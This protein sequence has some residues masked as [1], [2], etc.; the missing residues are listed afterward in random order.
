MFG[1]DPI[2]QI[3]LAVK[4]LAAEDRRCWSATGRSERVLELL[5]L[6]ERLQAETARAVGEWDRGQD[7]ALD[8]ALS[9]RSWLAHRRPIG[10]VGASRLVRSARLVR[11]HPATGDALANGDISCAHVDVLASM[12]RDR[13]PEY[14]RNEDTLLD[15]ARALAPDDFAV[16]AGHWRDIADDDLAK[17]EARDRYERRHVY[18]STTLHGHGVIEGELDAEGTRALLAALDLAAPPDPANGIAPPCTPSQRRADGLVDIAAA[19]L[20]ARGEGGRL[21]VGIDAVIDADTLAG[22]LRSDP[23]AVRCEVDGVGPIPPVTAWRLACDAA[24]RRVVMRGESEVLDLGRS[25]R[26]RQPGPPASVGVARPR[27]RVS[28]VRATRRVVRRAPHRVLGTRRL[29]Q[30]RELPPLVPPSPHDVPRRRL[31]DRAETRRPLRSLR[32][33]G[34]AAAQPSHRPRTTCGRV[35]LPRS[36]ANRSVY[37]ADARSRSRERAVAQLG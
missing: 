13:E 34:V 24:V 37:T 10:R 16:V 28:R 17:L 26:V 5:E 29:D 25:Q 36:G 35:T 4:D 11:D 31:D 22:R 30:P 19:F 33:P 3:R 18:V 23:R 12:V 27:V 21:R 6:T 7:W 2:E 8:G 15:A 1:S 20:A 9:P 32:A 14:A